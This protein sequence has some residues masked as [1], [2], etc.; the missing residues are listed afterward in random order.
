MPRVRIRK[1]MG[2]GQPVTTRENATDIS[3][4]SMFS[5]SA[6]PVTFMLDNSWACINSAEIRVS[7]RSIFVRA[8]SSIRITPFDQ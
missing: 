6:F 8:A 3:G 5:G 4:K 2:N 7:L 1:D